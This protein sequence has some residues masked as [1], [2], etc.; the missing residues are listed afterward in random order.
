M[1][2]GL[3]FRC[4]FVLVLLLQRFQLSFSSFLISLPFRFSEAAVI[5]GVYKFIYIF[6]H[7]GILPIAL[8]VGSFP[9]NVLFALDMWKSINKT[10]FTM[11]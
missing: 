2:S 5:V 9:Q 8:Y 10:D 3:L 11:N 4:L 7:P 1:S 6:C